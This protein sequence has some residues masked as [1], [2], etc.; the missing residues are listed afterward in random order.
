MKARDIAKIKPS[1]RFASVRQPQRY[2]NQEAHVERESKIQESPFPRQA[3]LRSRSEREVWPT[4]NANMLSKHGANGRSS[5][6]EEPVQRYRR[7]GA[8]DRLFQSFLARTSSNDCLECVIHSWLYAASPV[9][10]E[11]CRADRLGFPMCEA[12][13]EYPCRTTD[14]KRSTNPR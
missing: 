9:S 12:S 1:M 4:M 6:H 8:L 7:A 2:R 14:E 13:I 11:G 5:Q 3:L 10:C